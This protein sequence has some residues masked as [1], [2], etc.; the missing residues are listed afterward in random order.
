M[1]KLNAPY[2]QYETIEECEAILS[3]MAS[4][5]VPAGSDQAGLVAALAAL[6]DV[7]TGGE[8]AAEIEQIKSE[9]RLRQAEARY[10]ALVEQ[11][12]AVSFLAPLDGSTSELYV[13]PQIESLLGFTAEEWLSNPILW[14]SQLHPDDQ[15]R[16]QEGFAR[17]INQGEHFKADYRFISKDGRIVWVHGEARVINDDQGRPLFLQGVAFDITESKTAEEKERLKLVNVHLSKARDEAL[18]AS[19]AKSAFLAN[20]SHELRTPL[21]AI[22]GFSEMLQEDIADEGHERFLPD[23]RQIHSSAKHLLGTIGGILDLSKI[24]AGKM[25]IFL[26]PFDVSD[27][28]R[29]VIGAALPLIEENGNCLEVECAD[30]VGE[31]HADVTKVRQIL[32]NLISNGA[33]FTSAGTMTLSAERVHAADGDQLRIKVKD[34][35]IGMSPDQ[36]SKLFR[37]FS[38][39]DVS[40]TRKYGG[41]GLGLTITQRFCQMMGGRI[42]VESEVGRGSTFIVTLPA[43]VVPLKEEAPAEA[44]MLSFDVAATLAQVSKTAAAAPAPAPVAAL[45]PAPVPVPAAD[46]VVVIDDDAAAREATAAALADQGWQVLTAAT[47][48]EGLA[49][50]DR[51]QPVAVV[52]DPFLAETDG[53]EVLTAIKGNPALAHTPVLLSSLTADRGCAFG[54]A[55]YVTR[56]LDAGR[57][58]RILARYRGTKAGR[59]VLVV[60]PSPA[61]REAVT[62]VAAREGWAVTETDSGLAALRQVAEAPPELILV[63][64][65]MAEMNGFELTRL[66]GRTQAGK[67]IPVVVVAAADMTADERRALTGSVERTAQKAA[68]GRDETLKDLRARVAAAIPIGKAGRPP[69]ATAAGQTAAAAEVQRELDRVK[70]ELNAANAKLEAA[71]KNAAWEAEKAELLAHQEALAA[72]AEEAR[73]QMREQ[74]QSIE[75]LQA[76][77]AEGWAKAESVNDLRAEVERLEATHETGREQDSAAY[78]QKLAQAAADRQRLAQ[79][80]EAVRRQSQQHHEDAT[81]LRAEAAAAAARKAEAKAKKKA[82][83]AA[84][85]DRTPISTPVPVHTPA[86]ASHPTPPPTPASNND[87]WFITYR[88]EEDQVRKLVSTVSGVMTAFDKGLLR[89]PTEVLASRSK[90][91]PFDPLTNF[92]EFR[93]LLPWT[94][95]GAGEDEWGGGFSSA[96]AVA[97]RKSRVVKPAPAAV[98][99]LAPV[100]PPQRESSSTVTLVI[101][102]AVALVT[103]LLV[104]Q[105]FLM[106]FWR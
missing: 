53:W 69:A 80:L 4:M 68:V 48:A 26:E 105:Y 91:G 22:V 87:R 50:I 58:T 38:Q 71:S 61:N 67:T 93:D 28:I 3:R 33:K 8:T 70:A 99:P 39:A 64:L 12:P 35:G 16:W 45:P 9:N 101:T 7:A 29:D 34:S 90:G 73:R 19:K 79:E 98:Q 23:L 27:L 20:M 55:D 85:Q 94:A 11:I 46:A 13:S 17:T 56:P 65:A 42:D 104:G 40:T 57:L 92:P 83:Q 43:H 89:N 100:M 95:G 74:Q 52:L 66:L 88:D 14:F 21:N 75:L 59:R 2:E 103:A 31:M 44:E 30:D 18:E 60:D 47:K 5:M 1:V 81:R 6:T 51:S 32:F 77:C 96:T 102:L 78:E 84:L 36:V 106:K 37:S 72:K 25:D 82:A 41:T 10:K 24:E 49:L 62:K 15:D 63:D 54:A 86:R 97:A 76:E